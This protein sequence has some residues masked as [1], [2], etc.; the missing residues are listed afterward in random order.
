MNHLPPLILDLSIILLSA[1]VI[2]ILFKKLRQPVV[3]GYVLAGFI[4]GPN[5]PLYPDIIDVPNIKTWAELG[6][7]FLLFALGLEFS[8]TKLRRVGSTAAITGLFEVFLM[9]TVGYL[10]GQAIGFSHTNSL[11]LGGIISISST[12]IIFKTYEELKIKNK[13]FAQNVMGILVVEDVVAVLLL[14]LLSTLGVSQQLEGGEVLQA[15]F[16]L[17][18]FLVVWFAAGILILPGLLRSLGRTLNEEIILVVSLGLCFGMVV[19]ASSV[20]FSPAL[21]A[22]VMGSLLAET[23]EAKRIEHL[24]SPLKNLFGAIFFVSVGM[25]IDPSIIIDKWPIILLLAAV[26]IL[27]KFSFATVGSLIAGNSLKLAIPIGLSLTQ[28]GEFSF[29]IATLGVSLGVV[30]PALYPIAV[31]VSAITT[32]TTPYAIG[33]YPQLTQFLVNK[34][35]QRWQQ[36]LIRYSSETKTM[37]KVNAGR[38]LLQNFITRMVIY[39]TSILAL[40]LLVDYYLR[41]LL[42]RKV[43]MAES[44]VNIFVVILTLVITAP[45]FWA[46]VF[47]KI[48]TD[49]FNAQELKRYRVFI[50]GLEVIRTSVAF[51]ILAIILIPIASVWWL[52][53]VLLMLAFT[54]IGIFSGKLR[55]IYNSLERKF[56]SN[57]NPQMAKEEKLIPLVGGQWDAYTAVLK[58]SPFSSLAG[59][60]LMQAKIRERYGVIVYLVERGGKILYAPRRDCVLFPGDLIS[61]VGSDDEISRFRK[62]IEFQLDYQHSK[63]H[64]FKFES[65]YI[66]KESPLIGLPI[67]SSQLREHY[68]ALLIAMERDGRRLVN[69]PEK[70]QFQAGDWVWLIISDEKLIE[71][72]KF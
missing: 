43:E 18:F 57:L 4:V 58:V 45:F 68:D 28:I 26:V 64:N 63:K 6:V 21:G 71:L 50:W 37:S 13:R 31:M 42:I 36:N 3:L 11:F 35:P 59:Q 49:Y 38:S 61:V 72:K 24:T 23:I 15:M 39:T 33:Y 12:T 56:L 48:Q 51:F 19:F 70:Y 32:F 53:I 29:I 8:F 62:D 20:G 55:P 46:L 22:F 65:L 14:V 40:A 10:I 44:W 1:G 47:G 60:S 5:F 7:I 66:N 34:I 54:L 27:G 17:F 41:P 25:L 52:L 16:K 2:A 69:P 30:D 9:M 67:Y